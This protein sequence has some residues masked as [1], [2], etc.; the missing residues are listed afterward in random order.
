[1]LNIRATCNKRE[2]SAFVS[3]LVLR[4]YRRDRQGFE[5]DATRLLESW[6]PSNPCYYLPREGRVEGR[7]Y[8]RIILYR[9]LRFLAGNRETRGITITVYFIKFWIVCTT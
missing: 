5:R 3:V 1:V 8:L 4:W 7:F 2:R 9:V 6:E